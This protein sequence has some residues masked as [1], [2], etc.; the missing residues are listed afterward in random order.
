[1]VTNAITGKT[2][3]VTITATGTNQNISLVPTGTG[4]VNVG[5]F[6]IS[7]VATPVNPAD[8]AT[9]Q[10][11]DEIAQGLIVKA[12]CQA[13]TYEPLATSTGGT[14]T[15]NGGITTHVFTSSGS[16]TALG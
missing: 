10:Y 3:G 1:V 6:V 11:V 2:T 13:A 4:T 5:N 14:I 12:A 8:A 16:L 9:K 15:Y 7:N